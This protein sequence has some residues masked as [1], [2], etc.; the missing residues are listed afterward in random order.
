MTFADFSLVAQRSCSCLIRKKNRKQPSRSRDKLNFLDNLLT[1]W[2]S[3][4]AEFRTPKTSSAVASRRLRNFWTCGD[5][6]GSLASAL[7]MLAYLCYLS[8]CL[9]PSLSRS[10][11][12]THTHSI[13]NAQWEGACFVYT[14]ISL[15]QSASLLVFMNSVNLKANNLRRTHKKCFCRLSSLFYTLA[16]VLWY[17]HHLWL[18]SYTRTIFIVLAS[19]VRP[20]TFYVLTSLDS[21]NLSS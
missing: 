6:T 10:L 21:V 18:Y 20:S 12:H 9:Y 19:H 7:C 15:P 3:H 17:C 2:A 1:I 5:G 14:R 13:I 4:F 11:P 16:R 8:M